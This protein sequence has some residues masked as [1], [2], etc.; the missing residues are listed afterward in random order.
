MAN[1]TVSQQETESFIDKQVGERE[2]SRSTGFGLT[3]GHWDIWDQDVVGIN[4]D[5]I[6][7]MRQAIRDYVKQITDHLDKIDA[8]ANTEN[9]FRSESV[10]AAVKAYVG[11]VKEYAMNLV[12]QLLSFSDKLQDVSE[13]WTASTNTM[14]DTVN[15]SASAFGVG[16]TY[17]ETK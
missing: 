16:T 9:A 15:T 17:T 3:D 10:K 7:E 1:W 14:G 13:A 5:K 8:T 4:V 12:S 11:K 6:P 2:G